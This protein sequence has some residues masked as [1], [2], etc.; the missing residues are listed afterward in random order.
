MSLPRFFNRVYAAAGG[1]LS[2]S[3]ES[4]ERQLGA[5][6]IG[7][8]LDTEWEGNPNA[9]WTAELIVNLCARLYGELSLIGSPTWVARAEALACAINPN[10]AFSSS[11]PMVT[12]VVGNQVRQGDALYARADGWVARVSRA[13]VGGV[14]GAPNP[15]AAGAAASLAVAELF[16]RTFQAHVP[17]VTF[18][19]ISV[20][21]LDFT[22]T[23]G[24]DE[25][26]IAA[27]IGTV[28]LVGLGAVG[29]GAVWCLS[30]LQRIT[31]RIDL[32]DPQPI[33]ESNLQ[34]YVLALDAHIAVLKTQL[35]YEALGPTSVQLVQR[36]M[37]FE[38]AADHGFADTLAVSVDNVPTR[39][40][41]QAVLPRLAINGWT[42]ER[43]LGASWHHFGEAGPC[44]A[45]EYH[46]RGLGRSQTQLVSDA[47]GIVHE[48]AAH[49][50]V[51]QEGLSFM[52][53]ETATNHL[54]LPRG[55]LRHWLNQPIQKLYTDVMCGQVA[56]DLSGVGRLEAVPLAHQSTLAGILM[57]AELIR[58]T[59]P[60]LAARSSMKPM[61][62]WDDVL[63]IAPKAWTQLRAPHAHC[64][65]S[66]E[67]YR[68]RYRRKWSRNAEGGSNL[69][70]AQLIPAP[71]A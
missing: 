35:A 67:V 32:I 50:W 25:S 22:E 18:K 19:D 30:R 23:G 14:P 36:T 71:A 31:G 4:L 17:K 2:L 70:V 42:S 41:V 54:K 10:V 12:L 60:A 57:A 38:D 29:S 7:V 56:L 46:P 15:L 40:A 39:R 8:A 24:I 5:V 45:C 49:L 63:H 26:L 27:S 51:N 37:P 61:I 3:A 1:V 11:P 58:R 65:C 59:D 28:G 44:L 68:N 6:S 66:D 21:L 16:R 48:R 9:E 69:I 33:E 55:A 64:I 43:G 47:F 53:L 34:R 20:S 52:D 62:V 13:P